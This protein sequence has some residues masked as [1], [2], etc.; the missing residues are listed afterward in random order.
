M[1]GVLYVVHSLPSGGIERLLLSLCSHAKELSFDP[2]ICCLV[3]EGEG[4][5]PFR[6]LGVPIKVLRG[7]S[8]FLPWYGPRNIYVLFQLVNHIKE[9]Q[10]QVVQGEM[11]FAGTLSRIAAKVCHVPIILHGYHNFYTWKGPLARAID[12]FLSRYTNKLIVPTQAVLDFTSK[13]LQIPKEKFALIPNG[14]AE[15]EALRSLSPG[16]ALRSPSLSSDGGQTITFCSRF[17][18]QKR[19]LLVAE[20]F[21][22]LAI[23][24]PD[25]S[26]RAIGDGPLLHQFKEATKPLQDKLEIL[27]R[28]DNALPYLRES[29]LLLLPSTREGFGLVPGEAI[30][31]GCLVLL[32]SLP[33]LR[34]V[35]GFLGDRFFLSPE[36]TAKEWAQRALE[37]L[38]DKETEE[39]LL[40]QAQAKLQKDFSVEQ[41][42]KSYA[43][44]YKA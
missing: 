36:A 41:M 16:E 22:E 17:V 2:S 38:K 42:V 12:G 26:F 20:I 28:L 14:I 15:G 31:S 4:A 43:E 3:E 40:P 44:L 11:F 19:P 9:L 25:L 27:G 33:P 39:K 32:S 34:E 35:Y 7:K 6:E 10:P 23:A 37:L 18:E 13:Q 29:S 5:K 24:R 21:R 8:S 1:T 30:L